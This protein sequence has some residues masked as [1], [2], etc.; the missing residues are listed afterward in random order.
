[1]PGRKKTEQPTVRT[2]ARVDTFD[3]QS[4]IGFNIYLVGRIRN[5]IDEEAEVFEYTTQLTIRGSFSEPEERSGERLELTIY[6][7]RASRRRLRIDDIHSRDKTGTRVYRDYRGERV[8][9][10]DL[11]SGVTTSTADAMIIYG[12]LGCL[13]SPG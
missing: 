1:M 7:Q 11:P 6:G 12:P 3:V 2:W 13:L 4:S 8:P 9:V 5:D 10:L